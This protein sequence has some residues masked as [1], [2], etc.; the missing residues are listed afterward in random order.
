MSRC[1]DCIRKDI[2]IFCYAYVSTRFAMMHNE[3]Y[4]G[5]KF[6]WEEFADNVSKLPLSQIETYK[7]YDMPSD[8]I[9]Y[10]LILDGVGVGFIEFSV[11]SY[12][13]TNMAHLLNLFILKEYRNKGL[14]SKAILFFKEYVKNIEGVDYITVDCNVDNKKFYEK[15]GFNTE[16]LLLLLLLLLLV[17]ICL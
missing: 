4:R 17:L 5:K 9:I 13:I 14:G 8:N 1:V 6:R 10:S 16:V 11:K 3:S 12:Y 2:S 7:K 15:N